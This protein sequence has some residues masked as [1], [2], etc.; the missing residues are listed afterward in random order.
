MNIASGGGAIEFFAP[1]P[2]NV[3]DLLSRSLK[4]IIKEQA[5]RIIRPGMNYKNNYNNKI[6]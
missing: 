4:N 1:P 5:H 6:V 2:E 3:F